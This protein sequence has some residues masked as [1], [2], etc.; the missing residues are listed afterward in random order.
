MSEP[1]E[2]DHKPEGT[3]YQGRRT[4]DSGKKRGISIWSTIGLALFL[5][6]LGL[7]IFNAWTEDAK[8]VDG[9]RKSATEKIP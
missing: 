5:L 8:R 6:M 1:P 7:L 9:G 3:S 4:Q 2:F